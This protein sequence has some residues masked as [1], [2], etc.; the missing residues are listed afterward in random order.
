M[1]LRP[2]DAYGEL[3]WAIGF[4]E[5]D[6]GAIIT[7]TTRFSPAVGHRI[8]R[9]YFGLKISQ[10]SP[11]KMICPPVLLRCQAAF[12]GLGH[13]VAPKKKYKSTHSKGWVWVWEA[14]GQDAQ[15]VAALIFSHLSSVKARELQVNQVLCLIEHLGCPRIPHGKYPKD[16]PRIVWG[17]QTYDEYERKQ[18]ALLVP[19]PLY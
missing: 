3:M 5:A 1:M 8:T 17:P 7:S 18:A 2:S 16:R 12:G 14:F 11:S 15:R 9:Y 6:G 13:I 10:N 19:S 4:F